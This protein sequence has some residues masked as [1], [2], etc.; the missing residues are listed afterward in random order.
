M[1]IFRLISFG[2]RV[3]S[4]FLIVFILQIP[5]N[6]KSLESY[7]VS[8][9]NKFIVTKTLNRTGEDAITF[10][11]SFKAEDLKENQR[12]VASEIVKKVNTYKKQFQTSETDNKIKK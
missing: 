1:I 3:L 12:K 2:L 11:K 6:G 4:A 9:G 7:L 5:F 10:V 8:A